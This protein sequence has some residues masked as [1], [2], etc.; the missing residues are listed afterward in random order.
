MVALNFTN[1]TGQSKFNGII[2]YNGINYDYLIYITPLANS[3]EKNEIVNYFGNRM[4]KGKL[5]LDTDEEIISNSID[6]GDVSAFFIVTVNNVNNVASG[7]LQ[8]YNWC[9]T[10]KG[11]DDV[12]I[13]DVCK[14]ASDE[15]ILQ[16][17]NSPGST[18]NPVDAMFLLMEQ[19]IV[20]NLGKTICRKY[21]F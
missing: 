19:L 16:E 5:C 17:K 7:S 14:L 2:N 1:N 10:K 11:Y 9:N 21:S 3:I 15:A 6:N 12:W 20:Q 18:G 4:Y 13:N 8:I